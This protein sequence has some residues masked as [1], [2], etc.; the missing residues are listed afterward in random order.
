[1]CGYGGAALGSTGGSRRTAGGRASW[2][3]PRRDRGEYEAERQ[4]QVPDLHEQAIGGSVPEHEAGCVESAE[5]LT[6]AI[7]RFFLN[8]HRLR[9]RR[10]SFSALDS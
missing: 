10:G 6:S 3:C 7:H 2:T 4:D 1:V 9:A 8:P 5:T